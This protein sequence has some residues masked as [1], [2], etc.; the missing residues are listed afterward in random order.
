[1]KKKWLIIALV[2]SVSAAGLLVWSAPGRAQGVAG[3]LRHTQDA[4]PGQYIV[5]LRP[6]T[7]AS[8]VD[9]TAQSLTETYGGEVRFVYEHALKG[10]SVAM[11]EKAA[12]ELSLDER[13]EFVEENGTVSLNT[14]QF[15]P[16]W[17]LDRIDQRFRP[18]SN[19][20]TYDNTGAGV[21]AYVIDTGIRPTHQEFLPLGRAVTGANYA[22]SGGGNGPPGCS[23][24]PPI[25]CGTGATPEEVDVTTINTDCNGHG[26]HV[27]GTIG[28]RTY[29]V[30]KNVRLI[31]VRVLDCSGNGTW[32]GVIAGVNW[33]TAHH[34]TNPGPAV[35]NMSLGGF[36]I[37]SVDAAVRH[38]INSGVTYVVAAGNNNDNAANY[39]PARVETAV[40][41]GASDINDSRATWFS[42]YG[43]LVDLHAPGVDVVSAWNTGDTATLALPG[44]SMASPHVAGVA[45]LYLQTYRAALPP[46]VHA[47]L[48]NNATTGVLSGIPLGTPNR[49]LYSRFFPPV[50]VV[51]ATSTDFDD[52]DKADLAVW[53]PRTSVWHVLN[54][55]N[56]TSNEVQWGSEAAGDRLVPGDYDGDQKA[57]RAV[58]RPG[59]GTWY[60]LNSSTG[61]P[62]YQQWGASGDIPVAADYDGDGVTD[63]A[64]WRPDNGIWYILQSSDNAAR[65]ENWGAGALGDKPVAADYDGDNKA[66]LAVWRAPEGKWYVLNSSTG[67]TTVQSWGG[68]SFND[69]LVPSDYDGDQKTDLAVWRPGDGTWYILNSSTGA[70]RY[71][72]WGASGDI[73]VAADYDGDGKTDIAVW[74]P[75]DGTWYILNSST[76]APRYAAWGLRGD[77][78]VPSAYNRY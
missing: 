14:T 61:A 69:V 53:R 3:K 32:E 59:D 68:A 16:P 44:T 29:G 9:A 42:N 37:S 20:Y 13:V 74:R 4:V 10:F 43:P 56:G 57:D 30:A 48:V 55:S 46:E 27:A 63:I 64:V 36:A 18:L 72:Q 31:A 54:S 40:T 15:N 78:P 34:Q 75:G 47:A 8:L 33:V 12:E 2:V 77:V 71:Q 73:P 21:T 17:G 50:P 5:V 76:G 45:A 66:D 23:S 19:S 67:A 25:I 62:R 1:M 58:W 24:V 41:V 51:R 7:D 65:Y 39:S 11:S 26:T 60:I 22:Q 70:P 28:G 6:E 38:S 35:A 52:D 49:L